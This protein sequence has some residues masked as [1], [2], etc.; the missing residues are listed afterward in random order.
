ML[1]NPQGLGYILVHHQ[2]GS[3]PVES[4]VNHRAGLTVADAA[5]AP[6]GVAGGITGVA[7]VFATDLPGNINEMERSRASVSWRR[8]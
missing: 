4:T 1:V 2:G 8:R 5:I 3:L 7:A 6:L